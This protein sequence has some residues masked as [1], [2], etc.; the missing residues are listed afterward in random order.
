FGL[1]FAGYP[2]RLAGEGIR[3]A[4]R[5]A[6]R[7]AGKR[8]V[9]TAFLL[10]SMIGGHAFFLRGMQDKYVEHPHFFAGRFPNH[11]S[12]ESWQWPV[13]ITLVGWLALRKKLSAADR[14]TRREPVK[15]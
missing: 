1:K 5:S 9:T 13:P 2:F 14:F 4:G 7:A 15:K 10:A 6:L 11:M 8:K 12:A 3:L